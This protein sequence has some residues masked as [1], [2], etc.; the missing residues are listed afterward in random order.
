MGAMALSL[1]DSGTGPAASRAFRYGVDYPKPM[2]QPVSLMHTE[3]AEASARQAQARRDQDIRMKRQRRGPSAR[4][5]FDKEHW[6]ASKGRLPAETPTAAFGKEVSKRI[7]V[8]GGKS[9]GNISNDAVGANMA[10][11]KGRWRNKNDDVDAPS[12]PAQGA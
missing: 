6:E 1:Q 9:R 8:E 12:G 10:G 11:R 4:P 5:A 2:I 7:E 3:D